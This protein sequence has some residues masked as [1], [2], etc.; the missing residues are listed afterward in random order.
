MVIGNYYLNC[1]VCVVCCSYITATFVIETMASANA[2]L[3][4]DKHKN[5][6]VYY[7]SMVCLFTLL[8]IVKHDKCVGWMNICRLYNYLCIS[9]NL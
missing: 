2:I 8:Y 7:S 5:V 3:R 1:C 6:Q 9:A 4:L